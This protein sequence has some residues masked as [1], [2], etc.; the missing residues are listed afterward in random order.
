MPV[1]PANQLAFLRDQHPHTARV[2]WFLAMAPYGTACFQARV[3]QPGWVDERGEMTIIFDAGAFGNA[4]D[5][6]QGVLTYN[7]VANSFRDAGQD[8]SQ[9]QTVNNDAL[10][11]IRV[12]NNDATVTWAFLGAISGA[13]T[14]VLV[15]QDSARA[16]AG[17][18]GTAPGA[19]IPSTYTVHVA[20]NDGMTLWLDSTAFN[21][22]SAGRVRLRKVTGDAVN[23]V[24]GTLLVAENSEIEWNDN[25]FMTLP[26]AFGFRELWGKYPRIVDGTPVEFYMDYDDNF[27]SPADTVIPPKANGGPPGVAWIVA[28]NADLSFTGDRS[29]STEI[30]AAIAS[31]LWNRTDATV[32]AG[33]VNVAGTCAAPNTLRWTT[34]GF[35]YVPLDVVDDTA[36]TRAERVYVPAWIFQEGV[37]DP[38]TQ[39]EVLR[40]DGDADR[41][42]S[43]KFRVFRTNSAA[44]DIIYN[45]PDGA[46]CVLFTRTWFGDTETG[47]GGWCMAGDKHYR[48]N[49]RFVGWLQGETLQFDYAA[50]TVE[51]EAIGHDGIMRL[52][53]GWPFTIE[54]DA[55]P[56]DWYEVSNL[57]VDRA[58]HFLLEYYSTVNQVCDVERVGEGV[59]RLV[60]IQKFAG[61][62]IYNQAQED[63][64][65]DAKCRLLSD[66]QGILYAKRDPQFLSAA[67]RLPPPGGWVDVACSLLQTNPNGQSDWMGR[68][69]HDR[70][71]QP[72]VG[73]TRLGGFANTTPYLS[74]APGAAPLQSAD[75]KRVDGCILRSQVEA[76]L[77]S[78]L[79][80]T[81]ENNPYPKVPLELT[82]YWPV[83]DP[84]YQEYIEL[85]AN[86]PLD[87]DDWVAETF[88]VREVEFD[89]K[90]QE[91]T[92]LTSL[93]LEK[94]S[95][96]LMGETVTVPSEPA[97]ASPLPPPAPLPPPTIPPPGPMKAAVAWTY[98]QA[99][100]TSDLLRH[101][102][103]ST[104]TLGTGILALFDVN[105]DFVALGIA[106][107]D[108]VE[109]MSSG[110][111]K[112]T[113]V[114]AIVGA[115]QLTL[116]ADINLVP[117][118]DYHICGTQ[119]S[120][121]TPAL[122]GGEY[123]IHVFYARSGNNV[124]LWCLTNQNVLYAPDAFTPAW[125]VKL[126]L[127][128]VRAHDV[129]LVNAEF[130]G[131]AGP[132]GNPAYCIVSLD[133]CVF[134]Q[135]WGAV[136]TTNTGAAW[137]YSAFP[138]TQRCDIAPFHGIF[139]HPITGEV[140]TIRRADVPAVGNRARMLV[141]ADGAA[142]AWTTGNMAT[143]VWDTRRYDIYQCYLGGGVQAAISTNP[144]D[145][146]SPKHTPDVGTTWT[147][148][149]AAGYQQPH[150][151]H[152]AGFVGWYGNASD[153]VTMWQEVAGPNHYVL[154]RS[155]D[156]GATWA[157]IGDSS[158]LFDGTPVGFVGNFSLPTQVWY[159]DSDVLLWVGLG[160]S[161]TGGFHTQC[162]IRYTDVGGG[163]L[164]A[165]WFNK[166]GNW[167]IT[168]GTWH[169]ANGSSGARGNA[170]CIALPRV[171][172]NA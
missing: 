40:Q 11:V 20:P 25:D 165:I 72:Q 59:A 88:V 60:N 108:T 76:N 136:Y 52:I 18:C 144:A 83:F 79:T 26:G 92:C 167:Y 48:D 84:A 54:S 32:T 117:G 1:I 148:Y 15:Y 57:N 78:G 153:L 146:D 42:W 123:I 111:Y 4:L 49:I 162:R 101:H 64:L 142:F 133:D 132:V 102:V 140:Y 58:L 38:F 124:S 86:D 113:T 2:E 8:F 170:G 134:N 21:A 97:P 100:Y 119:W 74:R 107:G 28:G 55:T 65:G 131:I 75:E 69:D 44:E 31:Y 96:I 53:P 150:D 147:T 22:Y 120:N 29:Y 9:W 6:Q 151:G 14:T 152:K 95:N 161:G 85:T 93:V 3:N 82:G 154:L 19:K 27:N 91:G 125:S 89:D 77:W 16:T 5:S 80:L 135:G 118:S 34:P 126:T 35:R 112:H 30:G 13:N 62:S 66:R 41:G 121:V 50:G 73:M 149:I 46:L 56:V 63:L 99:G 61:A 109:N 24:S 103:D 129:D 172:V 70:K 98:D 116:F 12:V 47:V 168:F 104:A 130:R 164:G 39:V 43:A 139:V 166:M 17:W 36:Q 114:A 115:N 94:A 33:A 157:E 127:A 155:A 163:L 90:S 138:G 158:P 67:D 160:A 23:G 71:H 145:D 128:T 105:V 106:I 156:N 137:S 122:A 159:A 171:G 81:S 143:W 37:E 45:F 51:F 87:R 110:A 169:G 68:I 7:P 10:Y 141:S